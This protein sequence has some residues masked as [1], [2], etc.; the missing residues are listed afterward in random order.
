[1]DDTADLREGINEATGAVDQLV[2]EQIARMREE[3]AFAKSK[4]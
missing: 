4:E 2:E 3:R 1:M